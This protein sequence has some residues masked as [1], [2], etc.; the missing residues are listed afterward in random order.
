[1]NQ[2]IAIT[3]FLLPLMSFAAPMSAAPTNGDIPYHHSSDEDMGYE[4]DGLDMWDLN[5]QDPAEALANFKTKCATEIPAR[6]TS[7]FPM[8]GLDVNDFTIVNRIDQY[9]IRGYGQSYR[10]YIHAMVKDLTKYK[11]TR[12][13]A[14]EMYYNQYDRRGNVVVSALD[15]CKKSVETIEASTEDTKM[16]DRHALLVWDKDRRGNPYIYSCY[17]TFINVIS[18][19]N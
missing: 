15:Q 3:L 4:A 11:F 6:I 16:F 2:H 14:T 9:F 5:G 10:C 18:D 7:R 17:V 19:K 12:W 8:T 13:Q 1:M